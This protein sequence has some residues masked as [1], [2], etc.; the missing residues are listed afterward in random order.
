MHDFKTRKELEK[1]LSQVRK[2]LREVKE[3]EEKLADK[4]EK[5]E[6]TEEL[7]DAE[8]ELETLKEKKEK[9]KKE[10]SEIEAKIAEIESKNE[11]LE[12]EKGEDRSMNKELRKAVNRFLRTRGEERSGLTTDDLGIVIPDEIIYTPEQEPKTVVDLSQFVNK[13]KVKTASGKYP[14]LKKAT[15]RLH[16]VK[17]LDENPK[18]AKPQ[19]EDISWEVETYRGSIPISQETIDDSAVDLTAIVAN[20]AQDQKLNTTNA[21]IIEVLKTFEEKTISDADG[22]KDIVNVEIDAAYNKR[23]V[24][25]QSFFNEL[26]KLKDKNGRYLLQDNIAASS[27]KGI[28]GIPIDIVSDSLFGKAGTAQAFIG[29]LKRAIFMPDRKDL[30][31]EWYADQIYGKYLGVYIRFGIEAADKEAGFLVTFDNVPAV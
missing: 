17:E 22:L 7:E 24:A 3:N 30:S 12:E 13:Q 4:I 20:Y 28:L 10:Y 21:K 19:F 27:G 25:S 11:K 5:A 29:D 6:N 18:L 14:I 16:S 8:K 15:A 9:L 31:A 2:E 23:I 26:D 1:D